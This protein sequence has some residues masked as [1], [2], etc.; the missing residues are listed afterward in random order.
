MALALV[1]AAAARVAHAGGG[2][3]GVQQ[4]GA[5]G[6]SSANGGTAAPKRVGRVPMYNS[7]APH[8]EYEGVPRAPVMILRDVDF[9][10]SEQRSFPS[11]P[12]IRLQRLRDYL[13]EE[14][15]SKCVSLECTRHITHALPNP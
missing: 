9:T 1:V 12:L 8:G 7:S 5:G 3:G 14:F 11:A 2:T 4:P 13:S 10:E 15:L 6:G